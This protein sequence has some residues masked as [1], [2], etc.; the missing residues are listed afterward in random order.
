MTAVDLDRRILGAVRFLDATTLL[1]IN[2]PL[3]IH[4]EGASWR[5]N[6]GGWYVMTEAPG[7]HAYTTA[8]LEQPD[9][10]ALGSVAITLAVRDPSQRYLLRRRTLFVPR[11]PDPK[12]IPSTAATRPPDFLPAQDDNLGSVFIPMDVVLYPSPSAS[13]ASGWAVVHASVGATPETRLAGAL[14]RVVRD[15]DQTHLGSALSDAR[16]E[17]LIAIAGI[18]VTTWTRE[19]G[20]GAVTTK[21]VAVTLEVIHDA[22]VETLPNPYAPRIEDIDPKTLP[23]PYDL[24]KRRAQLLVR[25]KKATL[26]SGREIS[27][28]I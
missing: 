19:E 14:I 5:R 15:D 18:P 8:W 26:A 28:A 21:T 16:G 13:V 23:D 9:D 22:T 10:V 12:N 27:L 6:R 24:E 1:P 11:D 7:M 20:N 2:A 4:A 17:A 25:S 3:E